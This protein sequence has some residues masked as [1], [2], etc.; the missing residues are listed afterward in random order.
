[1]NKIFLIIDKAQNL[2]NKLLLT[3]KQITSS[4]I[5]LSFSFLL[6][7]QSRFILLYVD[8]NFCIQTKKNNVLDHML[9]YLLICEGG[10]A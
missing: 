9:S 10:C 3:K 6:K 1:M 5:L 2:H 8:G 7:K 4:I